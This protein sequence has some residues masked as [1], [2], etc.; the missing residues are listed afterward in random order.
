MVE[1]EAVIV[2]IE[3]FN[4]C[5]IFEAET[6]VAVFA[7]ESQL[8]VVA[9]IGDNVP[10]SVAVKEDTPTELAATGTNPV[11]SESQFIVTLEKAGDTIR[12]QLKITTNL[13]AAR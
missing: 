1:K 2:E 12:L 6:G 10:P 5:S 3:L 7:P 9:T 13:I 11:V 4:T 8:V